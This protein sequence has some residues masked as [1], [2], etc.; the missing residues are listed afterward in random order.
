[1]RTYRRFPLAVAMFLL[2]ALPSSAQIDHAIA[3]ER[4]SKVKMRDGVM[5]AA[6]IYHPTGEGKYPVLLQRTP[7]NKDL[8]IDLAIKAATR[9]YV[10]IVQDVRGRFASEGEWYPFQYESQDGYDTVEWAAALPYSDGRV[11]MFGESYV[12]ATQVLAAIANPPHL[13]GICPEITGSNYH[14]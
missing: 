5:L 8:Q 14:E 9:G 3:L 10:V 11:G 2:L 13:A 7:Y 12:G 1:M 4:D 6:D